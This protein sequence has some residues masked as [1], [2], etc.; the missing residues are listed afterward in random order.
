MIIPLVIISAIGLNSVLSIFRK[1]SIWHLAFGIL[2]LW[3]LGRYLEMYWSHMSKEY[4]FSSQYGLKELAGYIKE[5]ESKYQKIWVTDRYDQP[6]I[7]LLFYMKYSPQEFQ[8]NHVLT[9]RDR[10][11][12]STVRDFDKFHFEAVNFDKIRPENPNTMIV[13]ADEEIHDEANIIEEIYGSNGYK[14]FQI[15]AN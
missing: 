2:I 1:F 5:N 7:L 15:V 9:P 6:Y 3:Q 4:P 14:Y 12:F 8:R 11:G 13:G 10:F